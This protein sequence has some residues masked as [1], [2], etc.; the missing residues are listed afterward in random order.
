M[1]ESDRRNIG[2]AETCSGRKKNSGRTPR[3]AARRVSVSGAGAELPS[4]QR[5]TVL[6]FKL[7]AR[8]SA[9]MLG[10][11]LAAL[12]SVKR[13][14]TKLVY[15]LAWP[16]FIPLGLQPPRQN[17]AAPAAKALG[18]FFSM[19]RGLLFGVGFVSEGGA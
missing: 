11:H 14:G 19:T 7:V 2:R 3:N 15:R 13:P 6:G 16:S 18:V 17:P 1:D 8:A 4:S 9:D 5:D 12:A 10:I